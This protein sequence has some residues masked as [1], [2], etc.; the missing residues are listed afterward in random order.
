MSD[1]EFEEVLQEEFPEA[2][3]KKEIEVYEGDFKVIQPMNLKSLNETYQ[4]MKS[5]VSQQMAKDL[6]YGEIPG[7]NKPS[8]YKPGAEKLQRFFGFSV[9]TELAHAVEQWDVPIT[10]STYPLFHY[11][12]TTTIWDRAGRMID[13]CDGEAN[14]YES[15]WRW[16]WVEASRVPKSYDL[17]KLEWREGSESEFAFAIEK[18]ETGGNW[19]KPKE[20]WES[21][22]KDIAEGRAQQIK[23]KTSK[24]NM[25]DAWERGGRIYR[26]P[27]EDIHSQINTLIKMSQKRSYVGGIILAANA[28]EYF[29][30]DLEDHID[31]PEEDPK[32]PVD[33][34]NLIPSKKEMAQKLV[35]HVRSLGKDNP[36]GFIKELLESKDMKFSLDSWAEIVTLVEES[37]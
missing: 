21:W 37:A 6:D 34:V 25:L 18:K 33:F 10:D 36:D 3:V 7:T 28:S 19:G 8:L 9:K 22:E 24:G 30:Q 26:V 35:E 4:M 12:Y 2:D 11:R 20:Y 1:K 31:M 23:R 16:R 5:F 29:T 17:E 13:T 14:S 27:N 15:K 32:R